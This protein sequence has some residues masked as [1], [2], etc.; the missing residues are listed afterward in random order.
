MI[1]DKKEIDDLNLEKISEAHKSSIKVHIKKRNGEWR[2]G[3]V[4]ELG[5]SFFLFKDEVKGDELI[6]YL[7]LQRVEPFME[8]KKEDKDG[9]RYN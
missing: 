5:S 4:K 6:F 3:F 2:N 8:L 9:N 1:E 7:E